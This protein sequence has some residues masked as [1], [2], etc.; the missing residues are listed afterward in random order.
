MALAPI[1]WIHSIKLIDTL[2]RFISVNS[3]Q[4][5]I[6]INDNSKSWFYNWNVAQYYVSI[7]MFKYHIIWCFFFLINAAII[8]TLFINKNQKIVT[9]SFL[10][11]LKFYFFTD[12]YFVDF[13]A[14]GVL[15]QFYMFISCPTE[16]QLISLNLYSKGI[17]IS[18]Y[19]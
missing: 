9:S 13:L 12:R 17:F 11:K 2:W 16:W 8:L 14:N 1:T 4:L 10:I 15:I 19:Y 18:H 7:Y 5:G 6:L 3:K